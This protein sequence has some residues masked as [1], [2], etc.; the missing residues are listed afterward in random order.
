M[1]L[2]TLSGLELALHCTASLEA[3]EEK[4]KEAGKEPGYIRIGNGTHEVIAD[5]LGGLH[6]ADSL[7]RVGLKY[8]LTAT[9]QGQVQARVERFGEWWLRRVGAAFPTPAECETAYA[10]DP[11]RGTSRKLPAKFHRDYSDAKPGELCGTSD[12]VLIA[13]TPKLLIDVKTGFGAVT[14]PPENGQLRGLGYAVARECGDDAIG[15]MVLKLAVDSA[16]E[17]PARDCVLDVFELDDIEA[18]LC[19]LVDEVEQ[20]KPVARP[21]R[22]CDSQW[23]KVKKDCRAYVAGRQQPAEGAA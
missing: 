17:I 3:P 2:P 10:V 9:M 1:K 6:A 23:C 15:V 20:G 8:E 22:W 11:R 18:E 5:V 16:Q 13:R 14:A 7:A 19:R 21:G 4:K 12:I